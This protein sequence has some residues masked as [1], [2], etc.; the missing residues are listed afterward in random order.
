MNPRLY[1]HVDSDLPGEP[2]K[3]RLLEVRIFLAPSVIDLIGSDKWWSL[4]NQ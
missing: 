1:A 2:L 4:E 3:A